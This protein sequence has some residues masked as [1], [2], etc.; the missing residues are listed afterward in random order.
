M[1]DTDAVHVRD[2]NGRN[3]CPEQGGDS[4][5]LAEAL[6]P[7]DDKHFTCGACWKRLAGDVEPMGG[8]RP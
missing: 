4:I 6:D 3:L 7:D 1:P 5:T 8:G 2:D